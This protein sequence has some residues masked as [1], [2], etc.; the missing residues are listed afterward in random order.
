M[1]VEPQ[2]LEHGQYWGP[3]LWFHLRTLAPY[4]VENTKFP[5]HGG[6]RSIMGDTP[7]SLDG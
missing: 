7:S 1:I 6:F 5:S 2:R 3:S 4:I